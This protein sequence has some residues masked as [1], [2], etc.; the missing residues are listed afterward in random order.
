MKPAG[1]RDAASVSHD[2]YSH[3]QSNDSVCFWQQLTIGEK[4]V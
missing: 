4:G 3:I 1:M 2:I